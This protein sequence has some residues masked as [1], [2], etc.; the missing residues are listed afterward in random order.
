MSE[1][2][3]SEPEMPSDSLRCAVCAKK[4]DRYFRKDG[5]TSSWQLVV[6]TAR[7]EDLS[8]ISEN[9]E[10]CRNGACSVKWI[11]ENAPKAAEKHRRDWVEKRHQEKINAKL[12]PKKRKK[13]KA[14]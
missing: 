12:A 3:Y 11:I 6:V 10:V 1:E 9:A 5:T 14:A 13:K 2:T 7:S 8:T 4:H